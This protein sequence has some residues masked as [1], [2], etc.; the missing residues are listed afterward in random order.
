M[1]PW[2]LVSLLVVIV[3]AV[4]KAQPDETPCEQ[5]QRRCTARY[6]LSANKLMEIGVVCM[7][8]VLTAGIQT[9]DWCRDQNARLDVIQRK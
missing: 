2:L 7:A 1:K 8:S 5:L 9:E 4:V 3:F 6:Q